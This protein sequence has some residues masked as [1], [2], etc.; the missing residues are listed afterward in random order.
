MVALAPRDGRGG[1]V[2]SWAANGFFW[3]GNFSMVIGSSLSSG[4][5]IVLQPTFQAE[6]ALE[7]MQAE[8]VTMPFAWPHQWAKL[9]EAL[10][11]NTVDLSSLRYV[12]AGT[13]L[14]R[15]PTVRTTWQ[16]PFAFGTTETLTINTHHVGGH[17]WA[18]AT[19]SR[20]RETP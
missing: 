13:P 19:A 5:A 16:A 4:G 15:H 20:C 17:R 14:T 10:N 6:E 18:A 12:E 7:L 8:R 2:R 1:D 9:E 3:S 11:W